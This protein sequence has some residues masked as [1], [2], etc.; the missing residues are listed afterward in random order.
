ML[1]EEEDAGRDLD[2]QEREVVESE[3]EEKEDVPQVLAE[4]D[5][6]PNIPEQQDQILGEQTIEED[7]ENSDLERYAV[8]AAAVK[9]TATPYNAVHRQADSFRL[10][11]DSVNTSSNRKPI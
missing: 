2:I 3:Q 6:N 7:A 8:A 11:L 5:K 10:E 4:D 9:T 1:E